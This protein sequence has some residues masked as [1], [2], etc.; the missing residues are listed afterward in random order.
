M[1]NPVL[2][3]HVLLARTYVLIAA[4]KMLSQFYWLQRDLAGVVRVS[5]SIVNLKNL[6]SLLRKLP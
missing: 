6:L 4:Y 3:K 2:P 5:M 1:K